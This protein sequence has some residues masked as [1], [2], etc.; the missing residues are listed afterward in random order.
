MPTFHLTFQFFYSTIF[1]SLNESIRII[2]PSPLLINSLIE[3]DSIFIL[4][5]SGRLLVESNLFI[6]IFLLIFTKS[7]VMLDQVYLLLQYDQ[8]YAHKYLR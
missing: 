4:Y 1:I 8:L 5:D 3:G 7:I 6:T 2:R